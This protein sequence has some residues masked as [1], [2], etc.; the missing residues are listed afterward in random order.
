MNHSAAPGFWDL[1]DAVL[2][3]NLDQRQDRWAQFLESAAGIIPPDR[4]HR[5]PAV[6]GT[7]LPG[8]GASPWF[9]GGKRDLT[10]AA[11][12]GCTLS[13]RRA[14]ATARDHG[15]QTVLILEDDVAL[16]PACGGTL[17]AIARALQRN[18]QAWQICYLGFTDPVAPSRVLDEIDASHRLVEISGC[19]TTHAYLINPDLRGWILSQ[20]PDES[21]I[22]PWLARHRAID[23]WYQTVL[24]RAFPVTCVSPAV[25][26]QQP[27][28]SDIAQRATDYLETGAH[29]LQVADP[30]TSPWVFRLR[31]RLHR[32]STYLGQTCD[33]IRGFGKRLRGF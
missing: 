28:F 9:R 2:L 5:I 17:E 19:T 33:V 31:R 14:L 16:D 13:H 24:A 26:N 29:L 20:L 10:W 23:R 3:I 18:P 1:V 7:T 30:I 15:W 22:W 27:G 12:A 32:G 21:T 8:Y 11:R 6:L 25:M 4:I